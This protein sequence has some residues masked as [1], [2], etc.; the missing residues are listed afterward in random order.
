MTEEEMDPTERDEI[1]EFEANR[2]AS[3]EQALERDRINRR[4]AQEFWSDAD[5]LDTIGQVIERVRSRASAAHANGGPTG[6]GCN[7]SAGLWSEILLMMEAA[8]FIVV[9]KQVPRPPGESR[10]QMK[11]EDARNGEVFLGRKPREFCRWFFDLLG[12]QRGD[13][14]D[15]LFPGSGAVTAAWEEF[16][17][18]RPQREL[19]LQTAGTDKEVERN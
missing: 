7:A 12:A 5:T 19:I 11:R 18:A 17:G 10:Y 15:D 14:L 2:R 13:T 9:T 6:P 3:T 8:D 4:L 1:R 16:V